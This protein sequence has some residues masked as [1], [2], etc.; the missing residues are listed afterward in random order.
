[1][2]TRVETARFILA[3]AEALGI[4]VGT[5]G[6]DDLVM[7]APLRIPRASRRTFEIAL[8]EYRA[9][10]IEIVWREGSP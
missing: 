2:R 3:E 10:I 7:L 4:R 5:N 9:E 8:E 1:M 6:T